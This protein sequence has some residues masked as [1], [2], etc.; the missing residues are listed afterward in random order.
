MSCGWWDTTMSDKF[1]KIWITKAPDFW[2]RL[3]GYPN[4]VC[5]RN[6]VK[7][8]YRDSMRNE[9]LKG[10]WKKHEL[11]AASFS[12]F[13]P[14]SKSSSDNEP[15]RCQ[16]GVEAGECVS[17]LGGVGVFHQPVCCQ[18]QEH[19]PGA[20]QG[21]HLWQASLFPALAWYWQCHGSQFHPSCSCHR[22]EAT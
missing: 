17:L 2:Y 14:P 20:R 6:L 10:E 16:D 13:P 4:L 7:I 3:C 22:E 21:P 9:P 8:M 18:C 15:F 12:S 19:V 1:T 11:G 5:P